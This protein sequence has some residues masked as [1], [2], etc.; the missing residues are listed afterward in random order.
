MR[1]IVIDRQ[2]CIGARSCVVVAPTVFQ[3]DDGNLAFV[4]DPDSTDEDTILMAAQSCPVL[5]IKLY[6]ENGK[7]IFPEE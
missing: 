6:D 3:M 1:R 5:A 2:A 4:T 7:Q